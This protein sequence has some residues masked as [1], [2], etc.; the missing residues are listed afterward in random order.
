MQNLKQIVVIVSL[1]LLFLPVIQMAYSEEGTGFVEH[2]DPYFGIKL[3]VPADWYVEG[4][5]QW[6]HSD[7]NPWH[8]PM[9]SI[10]ELQSTPVDIL[11]ESKKTLISNFDPADE[12]ALRYGYR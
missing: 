3:L 8:L 12:S 6:A 2:I 10:K 4:D 7:I 5:N 1:V 9:I 11:R